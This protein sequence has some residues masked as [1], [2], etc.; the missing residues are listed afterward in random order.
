MTVSRTDVWCAGELPHTYF[1]D[2][3][4]DLVTGHSWK[5]SDD[6]ADDYL[7]LGKEG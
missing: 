2:D 1:V 7:V 5:L 6:V 3:E 4:D